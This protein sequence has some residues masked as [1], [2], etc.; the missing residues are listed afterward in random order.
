MQNTR[1]QR[2]GPAPAPAG[3]G[4][5]ASRWRS[6]LN[7][8]GTSPT[9]APQAAMPAMPPSTTAHTLERDD[10]CEITRCFPAYDD[11]DFDYI[12]SL[13]VPT[14]SLPCPVSIQKQHQ[15][16]CALHALNNALQTPV[17]DHATARTM[18]KRTSEISSDQG[19][20]YIEETQSLV[21][22]AS[23]GHLSLQLAG[24]HKG[25]TEHQ[26]WSQTV[27]ALSL[28]TDSMLWLA[29]AGRGLP[30]CTAMH[31]VCA[32]R[33]SLDNSGAAWYILDSNVPDKVIPLSNDDISLNVDVSVY[34]FV[35]TERSPNHAGPHA[36]RAQALA[37]MNHPIDHLSAQAPHALRAHCAPMRHIVHN[38]P[39]PI[40]RPAIAPLCISAST[41]PHWSSTIE[42]LS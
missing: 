33:L 41:C 24:S 23:D 14:H 2:T 25:Y 39:P 16:C 12:T 10:F 31:A 36:S 11:R 3:N 1:C 8:P 18:L 15:G 42:Q 21:D 29:S 30:P 4:V 28:A 37:A 35:W 20:Y 7:Q 32:V 22:M 19:W 26:T 9:G 40:L 5:N 34:Q 38:P 27:S 17:F 13:Y 6:G